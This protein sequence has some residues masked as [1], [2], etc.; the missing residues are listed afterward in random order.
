MPQ[1]LKFYLLCFVVPVLLLGGKGFAQSDTLKVKQDSLKKGRLIGVVSAETAVAV[2]T[3]IGLNEVWYKDYPRSSFHFFNDNSEWLQMDKLGHSFSAYQMGRIGYSAL[4]WSGVSKNKSAWYGGSL[5]LTY[6][7]IIEILDGYS[8]QW[9]FSWGDFTANVAGAALFTGQ[10]LGWHEQRIMMKFSYH[11]SPYASMNPD[12][13]GR[14]HL[15]R[16][17]KDYNGQT[18]W[19]SV[20]PGTFLKPQKKFPRWV[21]ISIGYSADGMIG[22][23][24]NPVI[25]NSYMEIYRYRRFLLSLDIDFSHIPVK[26]KG[27][28]TFFSILNVVKVP[29]PTLEYNTMNKFKG[30]WFYL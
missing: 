14:N 13:L 2:T 16:I 15:E 27:W 25:P 11:Y 5:G 7:L 17:L 30:H 1:T 24:S 29:F 8:S 28:R 3:L 10:Q 21:A 9:G 26:S 12:L 6:Q 20:S 19:L 22:A 23:R 18:Y 4:R